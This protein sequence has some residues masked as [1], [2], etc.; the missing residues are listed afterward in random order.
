MQNAMALLA[1]ALGSFVTVF[2]TT[3]GCHFCID[4]RRV[5]FFIGEIN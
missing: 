5:E 3:G 2:C 1:D 4:I